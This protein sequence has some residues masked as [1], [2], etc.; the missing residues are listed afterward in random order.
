MEF[1]NQTVII[2]QSA[3]GRDKGR[4]YVIIRQ[5]DPFY[6]LADGDKRGLINLK[7]KRKKHTRHLEV[8]SLERV[9][10]MED[11]PQRPVEVKNAEIRKF[12]KKWKEEKR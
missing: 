6:Y 1:D 3:Q 10:W 2:V 8:F 9:T 5:D 7:K 11:H 12:I 4:Y